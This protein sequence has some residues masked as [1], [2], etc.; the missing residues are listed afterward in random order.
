MT[1][2]KI[3]ICGWGNV[4][5]GLY[6]QLICGD[7]LYSEWELVCIGARRDNPRCNSGN[8]KIVRDIFA[9]PDEDIDVLVEL[10][11]GVETAREL[12]LKALNAGKHV[13]T[14]N[15]AVIYEH[16]EE[17]IEV[18][19]TNNVKI[20]FESAV[21]AGTPVVKMLSNDL[22]ANKISKVAGMLNGTTNFILSNMEE[23]ANYENV[24]Q[25][26]QEK[27]Y[28]EPDPSLDVNGTDAAHKIGILAS[29]AFNSGLPASTFHIEG[30]EDITSQDFKYAHEFNLTVKH[31]AV[32]QLQ[33]RGIE[34]RSHPVML[35][36]E[37]SLA[38]L[39]GV[40][41]GIQ[42]NTDLLGEFQVAGSGAGRESTASGLI[43]DLIALSK[44]QDIDPMRYP[45]FSKKPNIIDFN[46]LSFKYYV[47]LE[48]KDESGVLALISKIF[49]E[50]KI[51]F[52]KVIQKDQLDNGNVPMVIF[53]DPVIESEMQIA[54]KDLKSNSVIHNSKIIRIE[55]S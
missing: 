17:L 18:A 32:A 4:A 26:A 23:G 11:G 31:L 1:K 14:A 29:L 37:S 45:D 21:C 28:A 55:D 5:T 20:L 34:L 25:E 22:G 53:T 8:T 54:L 2:L 44:N 13:V 51:S 15:K 7:E 30:I 35:S 36:K 41:N 33:D 48:V 9:V 50:H 3:G 10:I 46:E 43:S 52:D 12:I 40:R 47:Y 38:G 6:E 27:G 24:L 16:G 19:I 42:I 49:A 39:K